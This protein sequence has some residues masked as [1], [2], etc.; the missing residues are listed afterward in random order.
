[1]LIIVGTFGRTAAYGQ[2]EDG[3]GDEKTGDVS[4]ADGESELLEV[5]E[6][7]LGDEHLREEFGVNGFTTPSIRK[8][9]EDMAAFGKLPY[10]ELKRDVPKSTPRDRIMLA[11][12]LGGLIADGFL[13]VQSERIE[14]IEDVGR[15]LLK[16]AKALGA[17]ARV[18]RHTNSILEN[19]VTGDWDSLKRELAATQADVEAAMVLLR[20][21]E[22]AHLIALGGWLR[23]FE[24]ATVAAQNPYS[25]EKSRKLGRVDVA[26]YFAFSLEGLHPDLQEQVLVKSLREKL[27]ALRDRIDV[28]EGKSFSEEDVAELRKMSRELVALSENQK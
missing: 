11:L 6:E 24:I 7:L 2:S 3:E 28:P 14:D 19:S 5:P 15:A 17:G 12:G 21:Q 9:F 27:E 16:H 4:G 20:D 13:L 26:G 8:I 10:A 18:T 1:M 22:V 23:A 25:E